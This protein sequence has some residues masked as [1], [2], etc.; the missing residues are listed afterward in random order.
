M[1]V[2]DPTQVAKSARWQND[3]QP[4]DADEMALHAR[5]RLADSPYAE[6]RC[7]SCSSRDGALVLRGRVATFYLKQLAQE[8]VCR[9]NG[10]TRIVNLLEVCAARGSTAGEH[11]GD[12]SHSRT[13]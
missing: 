8:T 11:G 1:T 5:Q 2:Q 7:V 3:P 12:T 10:F 13:A 9:G 6:S 4:P